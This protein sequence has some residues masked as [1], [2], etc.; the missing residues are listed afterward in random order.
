MILIPFSIIFYIVYIFCNKHKTF[1]IEEKILK[2]KWLLLVFFF[3]FCKV[4]QCEA[5][6]SSHI[7]WRAFK[8]YAQVTI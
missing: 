8:E 5:T 1:F 6:E 2:T 3:F 7:P 4:F